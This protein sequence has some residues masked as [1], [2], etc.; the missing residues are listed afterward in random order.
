ML[1]K[2]KCATQLED[3]QRPWL[4]HTT[5]FKHPWELVALQRLSL[6]EPSRMVSPPSLFATAFIWT[7]FTLPIP[8]ALK[9]SGLA[10]FL[11]EH[12]CP[13]L[14]KHTSACH[15]IREVSQDPAGTPSS[16]SLFSV[17]AETLPGDSQ[18]LCQ[19]LGQASLS[20]TGRGVGRHT[21]PCVDKIP[22]PAP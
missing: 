20:R 8:R 9:L 4:R 12:S 5:C 14:K 18:A 15:S 21:S 16:Q 2:P 13:Q 19:K 3:L 10:L 17:D 7:L 11:L 6:T 1:G 22:L